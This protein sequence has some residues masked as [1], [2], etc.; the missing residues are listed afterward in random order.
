LLP[1]STIEA[2]AGRQLQTDLFLCGNRQETLNRPVAATLLEV[3]QESG[4]SALAGTVEA[5]DR[6]RMG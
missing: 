5:A 4:R 2:T 1:G 3:E 6:R